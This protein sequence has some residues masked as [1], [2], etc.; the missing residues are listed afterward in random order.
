MLSGIF[1]DVYLIYQNEIGVW[2]YEIRTTMRTIEVTVFPTKTDDATNLVIE[3]NGQQRIFPLNSTRISTE[4][5]F[6]APK[7]WNAEQPNLYKVRF[8]L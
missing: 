4:Y 2:D 8:W 3:A 7:L 5:E 6:D 1:R